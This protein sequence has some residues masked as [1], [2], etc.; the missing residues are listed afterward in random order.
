MKR[1][2]ILLV[3]IFAFTLMAQ[4]QIQ[5]PAPSP[6]A[7]VHQTV[8]LTDIELNYSRPSMKGRTIFGE[9]VPYGKIWRTGANRATTIMFSD[10][11]KVG[12]KDVPAGTYALYTMP[13]KDE[14]T[15][16][17][18]KN[19]SLGGNVG[20]YNTEDELTRFTVKPMKTA[21]A[22]E[23]FTIAL[24]DFTS[25]SAN[26]YMMWA[27]TAVSIPI[28]VPVDERVMANIDKV[29]AGPSGNDY[30]AAAQY[31]FNTDRDMDK[32]LMWINKAMEDGD[33]YWVATWKARILAKKGDKKAAKVAAEFAKG[34]AEKAGNGDFVKINEDI[35]NTL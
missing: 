31:Y 3:S 26:L 17:I 11:V 19:T 24:N 21:M 32:A 35:L 23:S 7:K 4:A 14:W 20:G 13:G 10:D 34:L 28:E 27:N 29:M 9:L 2:S 15:V 12:G 30:Y 16:M 5:T 25:N 6:S 8:G 18:Y 33:K 1:I 22:T